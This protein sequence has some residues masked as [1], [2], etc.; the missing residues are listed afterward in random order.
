MLTISKLSSIPHI[1]RG[2]GL[3]QQYSRVETKK[4]IKLYMYRFIVANKELAK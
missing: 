1:A 3:G 2:A 4:V